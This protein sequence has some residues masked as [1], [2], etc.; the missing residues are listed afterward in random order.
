MEN[1]LP[2]SEYPIDLDAISQ[3]LPKGTTCQ[4]PQTDGDLL[5]IGK[6]HNHALQTPYFIE[7][8]KKGEYLIFTLLASDDENDFYTFEFNSNPHSPNFGAMRHAVGFNNKKAP[9]ELCEQ[10]KEVANNVLESVFT[11]LTTKVLNN[12]SVVG[13]ILPTN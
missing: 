5:E 7:P 1:K 9:T 8:C 2:Q 11:K 6:K 10:A 4:F 13:M 3:L 12:K